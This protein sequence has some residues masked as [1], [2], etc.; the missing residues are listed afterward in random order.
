MPGPRWKWDRGMLL[1]TPPRIKL[2]VTTKLENNHP[3]ILT[4]DYLKRRLI[5]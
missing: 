5:T 4:G 3:G 2:D 1:A